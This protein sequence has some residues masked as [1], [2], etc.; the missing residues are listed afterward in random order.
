V[1]TRTVRLRITSVS[2]PGRGRAAR[3]DTAVSEVSLRGSTS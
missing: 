3:D 1:R 2:P